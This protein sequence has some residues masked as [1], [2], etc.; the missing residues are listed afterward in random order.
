MGDE[1]LSGSLWLVSKKNLW[2]SLKADVNLNLENW[3][4]G[5]GVRDADLKGLF[6]M[7]MNAD[8]EYYTGQ[9]PSSRKPD[10]IPLSIPNFTITSKMTN[11]YFHYIEFF[12]KPSPGFHSTSGRLQ[13]IMI[14]SLS[15]FS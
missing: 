1:Y 2:I 4:K 10:T 6:S 9:N 7:K 13:R 11:G 5:F 15:I 14:T 8:G 12:P 3:A